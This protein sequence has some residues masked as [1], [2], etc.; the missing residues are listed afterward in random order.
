MGRENCDIGKY[1]FI[2]K[3]SYFVKLSDNIKKKKNKGEES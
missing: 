3:H 2:I 1:I